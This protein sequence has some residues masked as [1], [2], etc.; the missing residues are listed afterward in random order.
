MYAACGARGGRDSAGL[1]EL[2]GLCDRRIGG[3]VLVR[4]F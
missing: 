1:D 4:L 2:Q 3:W